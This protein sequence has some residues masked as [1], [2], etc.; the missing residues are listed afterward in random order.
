MRSWAGAFAALSIIVMSAPVAS[1]QTR[2]ETA[3]IAWAVTRGQQLYAFDQA[4]WHSTDVLLKALPKKR[5]GEVKGWLVEADGEGETV[6]YYGYDG[7]TPYGVF[8]STI[9]RHRV[10]AS[11]EI[12]PGEARDLTATQ[13]RM[14]KAREAATA[15]A[16]T[17]DRCSSSPFNTVVT[18]PESAEGPI[19]VYFLTPQTVVN[20]YPFGGHYRVTVS[21]DGKVISRRPFTRSCFNHRMEP[22]LAA[23]VI[24]HLLDPV[25]TEI[26]SW[27][28]LWSGKPVVVVAGDDK[29]WM[30][31][32]K[33]V[34]RIENP[35]D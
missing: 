5:L 4:A 20:D 22:R 21:P 29:F 6:L 35:A 1:A 27:L 16:P 30:V 19:D 18:Q 10:A 8:T 2:E 13:L 9:R 24:T 25:P 31:D 34:R 15:V 28:A 11:R 33:T 32:G 14:L 23:F 12:K 7:E 17:L 26:H 3:A